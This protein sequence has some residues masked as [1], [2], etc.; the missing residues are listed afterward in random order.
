MATSVRRPWRTPQSTNGT[1]TKSTIAVT[2]GATMPGLVMNESMVSDAP[3]TTNTQ[4]GA[5][6]C[7]GG[8]RSASPTTTA[9]T[10]PSTTVANG[11]I[12]NGHR[13]GP[14]N[15][16]PDR[17]RE[18]GHTGDAEADACGGQSDPAREQH[19]DCAGH[20]P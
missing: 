18:Q 10:I 17:R 13:Y 12:R 20:Q 14:S 8:K 15:S 19:G 9:V 16:G 5:G 4:R 3:I 1:P 6:F 11:V 2:S 7:R